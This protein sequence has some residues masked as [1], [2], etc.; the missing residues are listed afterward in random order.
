ML[1]LS[2]KN[3]SMFFPNTLSGYQADVQWKET[4]SWVTVA[5]LYL[6]FE[7]SMG[8]TVSHIRVSFSKHGTSDSAVPFFIRLGCSQ[9]D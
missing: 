8:C 7:S 1:S 2:I 4:F 3:L 5:I 6:L 9:M